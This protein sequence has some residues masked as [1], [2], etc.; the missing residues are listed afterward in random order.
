M[1]FSI[2]LSIF[3]N[4]LSY[5]KVHF[6]I[7]LISGSLVGLFLFG[8]FLPPLACFLLSLVFFIKYRTLCR[9]IAEGL[10]DVIQQLEY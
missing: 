4:L 2:L 8:V 3:L 9:K 1:K 6:P 5:F 10:A 7:I